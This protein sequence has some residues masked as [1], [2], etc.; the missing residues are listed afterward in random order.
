MT[1]PRC[2]LAFVL[3]GLLPGLPAPTAAVPEDAVAR[4]QRA[5]HDIELLTI[6]SRFQF[7]REQMLQLAPLLQ[8]FQ[9]EMQQHQAAERDALAQAQES[10]LIQRAAL[11]QGRA[12]TPEVQQ[13][14]QAAERAGQEHRDE[15]TTLYD[16]TLEQITANLLTPDQNRMIV[17]A[18][19]NTRAA[20]ALLRYQME[21]QRLLEQQLQYCQ[22]VLETVLSWDQITFMQRAPLAA[23]EV[24][25]EF[26]PQ[27]AP[28]FPALQEKV[29]QFFGDV[30]TLA[31]PQ[32]QQHGYE[33]TGRLLSL[34]REAA[35]QAHPQAQQP[36]TLTA[37]EFKG[38]LLDPQTPV[39][40]QARA[41][42]VAGAGP[43][44]PETPG[45]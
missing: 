6:I 21:Q 18:I 44:L 19:E 27:N 35:G 34:L 31:P 8:N 43:P 17:G 26:L 32:W 13:K 41:P 7:T 28:H 11:I 38:F 22:R 33:I 37:A 16:T 23:G 20:Q 42:F 3:I 30:I 15:A 40:L 5:W 12:V 24:A 39:L 36:F 9:L 10:L 4:G 2:F 29:Y 1:L 25:S 45:Q 14:I